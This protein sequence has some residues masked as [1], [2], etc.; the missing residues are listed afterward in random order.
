MSKFGLTDRQ[1]QVLEGIIERARVRGRARVFGSRAKGKH[2]PNSDID[3]AVFDAKSREL[4]NLRS[5]FYDS[6]LPFRID[7]VDF[8]NVKKQNLKEAIVRESVTV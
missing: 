8:D 6:S 4:A 7:V 5:Y 1:Y 2:R 3:L